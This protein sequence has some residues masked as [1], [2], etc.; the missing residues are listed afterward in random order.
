MGRATFSGTAS[1]SPCCRHA[2]TGFFLFSPRGYGRS[3][4]AVPRRPALAMGRR[5]RAGGCICHRCRRLFHHP[6]RRRVDL[7]GLIVADR[8]DP[9]PAIPCRR[10]ATP[11]A[12]GE[13]EQSPYLDLPSHEQIAGTLRLMG[14]PAGAWL[15]PEWHA[16]LA[17]GREGRWCWTGR[18]RRSALATT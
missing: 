2:A 17:S 1:L 9:P 5:C 7:E 12:G 6:P 13:T 3:S 11:R 16:R 10:D 15:T 4:V 8:R 14:E 18:P